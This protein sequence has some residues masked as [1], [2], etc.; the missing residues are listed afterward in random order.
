MADSLAGKN[1]KI[2]RQ[3]RVSAAFPTLN[4]KLRFRFPLASERHNSKTRPNVAFLTLT[5]KLRLRF[6]LYTW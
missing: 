5:R 3:K 1:A 4:R 2:S 6:Y